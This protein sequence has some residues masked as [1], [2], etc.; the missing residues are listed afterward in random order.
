MQTYHQEH[1]Q[2]VHSEIQPW[3]Q[4]VLWAEDWKPGKPKADK[5]PRDPRTGLFGSAHDPANW[6]TFDQACALA[7]QQGVGIGFVLTPHDPFACIDLDGC[8]GPGDVL[9][10]LARE[11][12]LGFPGAWVERSHSGH[13]L[14]VWVRGSVPGGGRRGNGIEAYSEKRFIALTGKAFQL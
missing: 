6:L 12:A 2:N 11:I 4:F 1:W 10:P 7:R 9:S 3:P 5:V 8:I 14:H 13:G